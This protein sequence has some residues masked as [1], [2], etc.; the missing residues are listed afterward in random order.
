VAA[1]VHYL[2]EVLGQLGAAQCAVKARVGVVAGCVHDG[3][4]RPLDPQDAYIG[5]SGLRHLLL[6]LSGGKKASVN[7]RVG[8]CTPVA[9]TGTNL[10][11]TSAV[12]P[13]LCAQSRTAMY[14]PMAAAS[15]TPPGRRTRRAS[16]SAAIR[17][18][19]HEV[20]ERAEE[21]HCVDRRV[22]LREPAG[23]ADFGGHQASTRG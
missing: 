8:S 22:H 11:A 14:R 7:P 4:R 10:A 13:P 21:E 17:R 15:R 16:A 23:V 5:E 3:P 2:C 9:S 18:S 20:V 6:Q 12:R 19:S 1:G